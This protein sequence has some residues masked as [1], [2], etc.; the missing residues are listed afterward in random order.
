MN[1]KKKLAMAMAVV[2]VCCSIG[3]PTVAN[4]GEARACNHN[5]IL[6]NT[7]SR[8]V[9]TYRHGH[10]VGDSLDNNYVDCTVTIKEIYY[11]YRCSNCKVRNSETERID[12]HSVN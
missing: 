6:E 2:A 4:A 7:S 9:Q 5:W 3:A 10:L 8:V 12:V 1:L 11:D